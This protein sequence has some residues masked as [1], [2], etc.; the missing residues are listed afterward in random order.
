MQQW[1]IL[2][3]A[4]NSIEGQVQTDGTPPSGAGMNPEGLTEVMVPRRGDLAFES[5]DNVAGKWVADWTSVNAN[6]KSLI[7]DQASAFRRTYLVNHSDQAETYAE[8]AAE[9]RKFLSLGDPSPPESALMEQY[10]YL[11]LEAKKTGQT[12]AAI[13]PAVIARNEAYARDK[14]LIESE[15]V[16]RGRRVVEADTL[17]EKEAIVALP[18]SIETIQPEEDEPIVTVGP[19][20]L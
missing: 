5:W 12:I 20:S 6:L 15:R 7:D 13:A 1:W 16:A 3:R 19:I 18:W 2:L 17:A 10:P 9:A 14:P 11:A 4:D 8:K